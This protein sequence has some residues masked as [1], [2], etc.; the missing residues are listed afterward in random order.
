MS[1]TR[2]PAGRAGRFIVRRDRP[3]TDGRDWRVVLSRHS[4]EDLALMAAAER[5]KEWARANGEITEGTTISVV[6]T[7]DGG[8]VFVMKY[9]GYD[10]NDI[11][12]ALETLRRTGFTLEE[13]AKNGR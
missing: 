11:D 2:P 6:D 8:T 7:E 12:N 9:L 1:T 4:R 10:R 5:V 3:Q 13:V